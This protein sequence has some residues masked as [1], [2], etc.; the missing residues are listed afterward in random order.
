MGGG[1]EAAPV[2]VSSVVFSELRFLPREVRNSF[3]LVKPHNTEII[4]PRPTGPV[5]NFPERAESEAIRLARL[6]VHNYLTVW[7]MFCEDASPFVDGRL[8][9]REWLYHY[10][11]D[12]HATAAFSSKNGGA[13]Y[14][15][16]TEATKRQPEPA[17]VGHI[18]G[19]NR[20][21]HSAAPPPPH[22][23]LYLAAPAR[24]RGLGGRVALALEAI[25]RRVHPAATSIMVNIHRENTAS[26]RLFEKLG[27]KESS[28]A[29][30]AKPLTGLI[31]RM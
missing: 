8:T 23:G 13:D 30:G 27:Y 12:R 7:Q 9:N 3:Y 31:K 14:L 1:T 2:C 4:Q 11:R 20:L 18:Y 28:K 21:H 10:V 22:I 17:G 16:Y 5:W 24:G 15:V 6:T 25:V 29:L 26:L 19:L